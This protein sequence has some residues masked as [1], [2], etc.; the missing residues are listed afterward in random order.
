MLVTH[1]VPWFLIEA[2]MIHH[3]GTTPGK[4]L[5][6]LFISNDDG[7]RLTY[8]QSLRRSFRVLVSGI[9]CGFPLVSPLCQIFSLVMVRRMGISLWDRAGGHRVMAGKLVG[10]KVSVLVIGMFVAIEIEGNVLAPVM[11]EMLG[12]DLPWLK[13]AYENSRK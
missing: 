5:M 9:G 1:L 2:A 3:F 4:A 7:S 10:W 8:G 11:V 6:N 13:E 12:K